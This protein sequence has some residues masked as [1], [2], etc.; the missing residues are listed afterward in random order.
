MAYRELSQALLAVTLTLT[1][2]RTLLVADAVW[3]ARGGR[4]IAARVANYTRA[5]ASLTPWIGSSWVM[6][7]AA[8]GNN[9]RVASP[10]RAGT[11]GG[12]KL[13]FDNQKKIPKGVCR[14]TL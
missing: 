3:A 9:S 4:G 11:G 13:R 5:P 7:P 14:V 6:S 10:R 2:A 1:L 12:A 8:S